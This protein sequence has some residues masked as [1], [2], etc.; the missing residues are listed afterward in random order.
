MGSGAFEV[1]GRSLFG[2]YGRQVRDP[3][4]FVFV[5]AVAPSS[6]VIS[7]LRIVVDGYAVP[8]SPGARVPSPRL[9]PLGARELILLLNRPRHL[10]GL[11]GS[12]VSMRGTLGLSLYAQAPQSH[13]PLLSGDIGLPA[14]SCNRG[15][16]GA[17]LSFLLSSVGMV[18]CCPRRSI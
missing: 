5:V 18:Y 13:W 4:Y 17:S 9:H 16:C 6:R 1:G 14:G 12:V 8:G 2:D 3:L 10:G 11:V 15:G 7:P